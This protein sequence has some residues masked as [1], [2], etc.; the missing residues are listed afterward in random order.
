VL[1]HGF[2]LF[3]AG[4]GLLELGF[5]L[6][7]LALL[8]RLKSRVSGA[9]RG[10]ALPSVS[11]VIPARDEERAIAAAV[12]SQ[13]AQN[14][15]DFEVIV[16]DDRSTDATPRILAAL[17]SENPRLR[18]V[19]GEDPPPGWL[20]KPH[21]LWEGARAA[22]G[23]LLL[24][25][26]ADV[27]YEPRCLS[28]A[29]AF[30]LAKRADFLAFLPRFEARGF[31]E[32][33]LMPNLPFVFYCGPAFL[34]NQ[35]RVHSIAVG[36][37]AGN[38]VRR[39]T[40][41]AIGGHE[42]LKNS[43]VDDVHLA[44]RAKRSGFR[45]RAVRAEGRVSVR[46]YHGFREVWKGFSKNTAFL[47]SGVMGAGPPLFLIATMILAVVPAAI[48]LAAVVGSG[49][50]VSDVLLAAACLLLVA[51]TRALLA[52]SIGTPAWPCWTHPILAVVWAGIIGHS[53][54]LRIIQRRLTW[55]GREFDARSA[56]F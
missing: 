14:Y 23:D 8:P 3:A 34:A 33:V 52:A 21:A 50:P 24:F 5:L 42:A 13:L 49:V 9:S 22:R 46:M 17:A 48:L 39:S 53:L 31:W 38:L 43:V 54:Y 15:A 51:G 11:I 45:A 28:E 44:I 7:N 47:F 1:T 55:R 18:V 32:N 20:G 16:V 41:D 6:A 4:F 26:D 10:G 27:R 40:Y 37:G 19:T 36:G 12:R 2:L 29:V 35:D 30:L 56:R 25:V